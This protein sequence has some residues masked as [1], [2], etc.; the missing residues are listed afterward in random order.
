MGLLLS[1]FL[2]VVQMAYGKAQRIILPMRTD[3]KSLIHKN[4]SL[5]DT[6]NLKITPLKDFRTMGVTDY[7]V[8]LDVWDLPNSSD[9]ELESEEKKQELIAFTLLFSIFERAFLMHNDM[10]SEQWNGWCEYITDYSKR[11]NF[12]NAWLK[13]GG[14]FDSRFEEFMGKLVDN[15]NVPTAPNT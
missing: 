10:S 8:N 12:R 7:E 14:T 3:R 2:K 11:S 13:S 9:V 5:L 1:L 6:R 4:P 15:R